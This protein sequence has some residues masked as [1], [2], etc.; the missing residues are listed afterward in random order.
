MPKCFHKTLKCGCV[1]RTVTCGVKKTDNSKMYLLCGHSHFVICD[2]CKKIEE[3]E[4]EDI[5][6]DMWMN[7]NMTDD[8]EYGEWKEMYKEVK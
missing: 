2:K 5:L 4:D 3:E 8:F 7:D 6:Y 1:I